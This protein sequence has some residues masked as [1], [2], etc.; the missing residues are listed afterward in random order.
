ML[1]SIFL[2]KSDQITRI[3][4]HREVRFCPR[5]LAVNV[6]ARQLPGGEAVP[7]A[8]SLE[9]LTQ[10][11]EVPLLET[12]ESA[13]KTIA[14]WWITSLYSDKRASGTFRRTTGKHFRA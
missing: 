4:F 3:G 13:R 1:Q 6:A 9:V 14:L 5:T 8:T 2:A 12:T 11:C 7:D 10:R